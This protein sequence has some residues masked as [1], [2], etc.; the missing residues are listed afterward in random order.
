MT[1]Q[2]P[3]VYFWIAHYSN[4]MSLPQYD[5]NEFT[6]NSFNLIEQDKLIKF[7][8]Y[9]FPR[10]LAEGIRKT[11]QTVVSIPFLPSY[12]VNLNN[13]KRIIYY[14]DIFISQEEYHL[15]RKCN[16]EFTF[17]KTTPMIESKYS[18]PICPNCGAHDIFVCKSCKHIHEKFE[19]SK[20]GM[21]NKCSAHLDRLKLTS[22]QF[23]REK[24]WIVYFL[25]TQELINGTNVKSLLRISENG[26]CEVI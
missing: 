4:G 7:G 5:L 24:R 10:D 15:C 23:H 9:P 8:L 26:D 22:G 12:E 18:S 16:K 1:H 13:N 19:D 25:G 3:L 11:E 6:E 17:D 21:C 2:H 14:R 20:F